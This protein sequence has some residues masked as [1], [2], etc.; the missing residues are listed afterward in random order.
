MCFLAYLGV[1]CFELVDLVCFTSCLLLYVCVDCLPLICWLFLELLF[2]GLFCCY[3]MLVW[4]W[5]LFVFFVGLDVL[6]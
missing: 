6:L 1:G 4:R 3:F 5:W 2:V